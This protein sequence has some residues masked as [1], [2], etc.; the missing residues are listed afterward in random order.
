[1]GPNTRGLARSDA[2]GFLVAYST[3]PGQVALDSIPG[4]SVQLSPYARRLTEQLV[5]SGKSIT[6]VFLDI[7]ARVAADTGGQQKPVALIELNRNLYLA[8]LAPPPTSRAVPAACTGASVSGHCVGETF[9]DCPDCP[10]MVVIPP[11]HFLMG[12][13]S[14]EDGHF[15]NEDP[16]HDVR[17][18]YAL[19]VGKFPVTR[20]EWRRYV[21][22]TGRSES[23][24][25][26]AWNSSTR[27]W[28]HRQDY[29]W[30][31]PGFSQEDNHPVVCVSLSAAQ[32]YAIWLSQKTG[33]QYRLLT[34]AE[35]E[36]MN[37]AGSTN[38]YFWGNTAEAQCR[39]ANG[40]DSAVNRGIAAYC[41]DGYVFTSPVGKFQPNAFGLYD[42][43]G[44]A[45]SWTQDCWH[46]S[47]SGAPTDGSA[48]TTGGDCSYRVARG[49]SWYNIPRELRA[50]YRP[51]F[52][53]SH[54]DSG[55]G[56]RLGR[57]D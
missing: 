19:A 13:S 27:L 28:E 49:G 22:T 53:A 24:N 2:G 5:L 4:S 46:D 18:D 48:W 29:G 30:Q 56:L 52:L 20:G 38:A 25:C 21:T 11:G 36:Y 35:Y 1:M 10:E 40:L 15:A 31:A 23:D 32:D 7:R 17:I 34:D 8:G 50:A 16:L 42:T 57:T 37:R 39:Y 45:W 54:T 14:N 55:V 3:E 43:T 41:N 6:D 26:Y 44:N 33:H 47:Y 9:L 51:K 12:S